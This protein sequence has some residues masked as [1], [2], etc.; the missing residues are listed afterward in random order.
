M[1]HVTFVYDQIWKKCLLS[2]FYTKNSCSQQ[3]IILKTQLKRFCF[4]PKSSSL[5]RAGTSSYSM[6]SKPQ[7]PIESSHDKTSDHV[8][9]EQNKVVKSQDEYKAASERISE[10]CYVKCTVAIGSV[11]G[12]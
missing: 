4:R 11:V 1:E 8:D 3:S 7:K 5:V 10:V 12:K 9:E 6:Q 2:I